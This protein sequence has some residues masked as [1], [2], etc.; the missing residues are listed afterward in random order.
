VYTVIAGAGIS[1]VIMGRDEIFVG[2]IVFRQSLALLPIQRRRLP[3][4]GLV[5][6]GV[7]EFGLST[8]YYNLEMTVLVLA[9]RPFSVSFTVTGFVSPH[10][11]ASMAAGLRPNAISCCLIASARCCVNDKI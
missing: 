3:C 4:R 9:S 2:C 7:V 6:Q 11:L 5:L 8:G 10:P 1:G